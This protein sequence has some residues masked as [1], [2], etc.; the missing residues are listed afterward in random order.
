MTSN[1]KVKLQ[2]LLIFLAKSLDDV[3]AEKVPDIQCAFVGIVSML[4]VG[5]CTQLEMDPAFVIGALE[6]SKATILHTYHEI[7]TREGMLKP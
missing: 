2:R 1:D 7:I 5:A 6:V 3:E 4:G